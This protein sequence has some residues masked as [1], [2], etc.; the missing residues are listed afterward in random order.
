MDDAS[1]DVM[2]LVIP[3]KRFMLLEQCPL[4]WRTLDLYV[5]RDEDVVFYV[6]QA[7]L[8]F[9]R[10]WEH[11]R[12]GF[13]GRSVIGRFILSNWPMSLKFDIELMSSRA[14]RFNH[15]GHDVRLAE[16]ELIQQLTPCFNDV[17]NRQPTPLPARYSRPNAPV[18]CARSL[19]KLIYEAGR[20]VK[21]EE[22][23]GWMSTT[24][25][26]HGP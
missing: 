15:L 26:G 13:K 18:R 21:A 5:F 25:P 11:L 6:G 8:A 10:V 3:L 23:Q 22:R 24:A 2:A 7:H 4:H 20:A 12:N 16:R 17:L 9:E 19:K 1:V 14:E